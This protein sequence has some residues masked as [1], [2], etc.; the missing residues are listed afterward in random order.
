MTSGRVR[1]PSRNWTPSMQ[2]MQNRLQPR[3]KQAQ[4]PFSTEESSQP[5]KQN[6]HRFAHR[7]PFPLRVRFF[8]VLQ[9]LRHRCSHSDA[10]INVVTYAVGAYMATASPSLTAVDE[11]LK[12]LERRIARKNIWILLSIVLNL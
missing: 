10:Q 8:Y 9:L 2:P 11:R 1:L 12:L 6:G 5:P 7:R 3:P 4:L